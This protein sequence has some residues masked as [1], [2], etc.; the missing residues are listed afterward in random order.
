MEFDLGTELGVSAQPSV[1][2]LTL[3]VPNKDREG[4]S[5]PDHDRWCKEAQELLTEIGGGATSFPPVDGTW[6]K[7]DGADLWEQ[8]RIIYTFVDPDKLL[9]NKRHLRNFLHRFGRDTN[10]GEVVC[11]FDGWFWRITDYKPDEAE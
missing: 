7:P 3:Y 5:I 10:Q 6:R 9:A 4:N 11:E 8:T 2:R 1:Q